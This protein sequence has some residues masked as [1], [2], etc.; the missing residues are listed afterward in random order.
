M[1]SLKFFRAL[2][3]IS[4]DEQLK[5]STSIRIFWSWVLPSQ[6]TAAKTRQR[7]RV[8]SSQLGTGSRVISR[9]C[10]C[11]PSETIV[12]WDVQLFFLLE[13]IHAHW[14]SWWG[15]SA[16]GFQY[17]FFSLGSAAK[18]LAESTHGSWKIWQPIWVN[19]IIFH[20]NWKI[21]LKKV[22]KICV[23]TSIYVYV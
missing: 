18:L 16:H 12:F 1:F 20:A 8:F 13:N 23:N 15:I 10:N 5:N 19:E 4:I 9:Q 7:R 22:S 2:V 14:L 11:L 6:P 17:V 21:C 3:M